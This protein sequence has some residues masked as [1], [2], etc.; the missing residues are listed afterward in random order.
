MNVAG[1]PLLTLITFLPVAGALLILLTPREAGR[2]IRPEMIACVAT[3]ATFLFSLWLLPGFQRSAPGMQFVEGPIPWIPTIGVQYFLGV[4]G[5][6]LPLVLLT[7]LLCVVAVLCS[8]GPIRER[9]KEYYALLLVL[10]TGMV[11][12][13]VSLDLVLF[14][15]FWETVLIPMYFLIGVWGGPRRAYASIKFFLYTLFGSVFLL[16]G[17]LVLAF[18]YHA[19]TGEY[20]FNLLRLLELPLPATYQFGLFLA[21]F[22]GFAVKVPMVPFHTWLPDAHVEAPTAG[23]VLLAGVLLKMGAYG[24]IRFNLPLFPLASH[25]LAPAMVALGLMGIIYGALVT[26]AQTDLKKLIAYSSVS[27]MGFIILGLFTFNLQGLTGA[28]L[29]MVNHGISTGALFLIVGM[30]YERRHTRQIHDLGG[31]AARMPVFATLFAITA[32]SSLG[33]PGLNNFVGE[34]LVLLGAFRVTWVWTALA[35]IGVVLSAA[36]LLWC[37]QRMMFGPLEKPENQTLED[38]TRLEV[39]YMAPLILL[40][41]WIGLAPGPT[42]EVMEAAVQQVV[43]QVSSIAPAI[44]PAG[45]AYGP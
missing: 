25:V 44:L 28:V 19:V 12:V 29:Q 24:L 40:M 39:A 31:L 21:F 8:L 22:L 30:I 16:L 27:H 17:I 2:R 26:L 9:L 37:Y 18:H 14:Y 41:F 23:S 33:L 7:T 42:I 4:D 34:F 20:T 32:F 3:V 45:G 10:E 1:F 38:C 13:F 36:Y 6:S 5:I 35:L 11:G 43:I 15:V